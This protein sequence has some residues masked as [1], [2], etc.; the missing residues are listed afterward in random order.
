MR[1]RVSMAGTREDG[2][3]V[4]KEHDTGYGARKEAGSVPH[5]GLEKKEK[6]D[7][8]AGERRSKSSAWCRT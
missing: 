8:F 7:V 5:A 3:W 2:E 6:R 4:S 1:R